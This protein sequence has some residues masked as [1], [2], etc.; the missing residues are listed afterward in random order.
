MLQCQMDRTLERH[1]N[2]NK[3]APSYLVLDRDIA[4]LRAIA[5]WF[6]RDF[7]R[8]DVF[9]LDGNP[10][11]QVQQTEVFM[12]RTQLVSI[13]ERK[14]YIICDASTM[15][16][17]AQNKILKTLEDTTN[18]IFLLLATND[19]AILSTIKS[20]CVVIYPDPSPASPIPANILESASKI[21]FE[22][23]S[24]DDALS[25]IPLLVAKENFAYTLLAFNQLVNTP[26]FTIAKRNAILKRLAIINRNTKANCNAQ[27]AF[28]MLLMEI[29]IK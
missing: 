11:I 22:C 20:R 18:D 29:F 28:D 17:A 25:F 23:K 12:E 14:L 6:S 3:L 2:N 7:N 26:R 8:A 4:K 9:R 27:N 5:E 19:D 15:T 16:Q 13:G 1:K 21:L 24:L 10:N